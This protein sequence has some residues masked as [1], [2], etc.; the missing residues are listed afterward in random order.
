MKCFH[1]GSRG[2]KSS[3]GHPGTWGVLHRELELSWNEDPLQRPCGLSL[4][5]R[6][7]QQWTPETG[8]SLEISCWARRSLGPGVSQEGKLGKKFYTLLSTCQ[9]VVQEGLGL[10]Q[11]SVTDECDQI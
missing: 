6:L 8:I 5:S 4:P 2:G 3:P 9:A 1:V 10:G 7:L 11:F